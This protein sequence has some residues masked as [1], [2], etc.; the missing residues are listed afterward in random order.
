MLR[1]LEDARHEQGRRVRTALIQQNLTSPTSY[2]PFAF[3]RDW[4]NKKVY[5]SID[6]MFIFYI[7]LSIAT[8]SLLVTSFSAFKES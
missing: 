6:L 5:L 8:R 4:C 1:R 3:V 7:A 2:T